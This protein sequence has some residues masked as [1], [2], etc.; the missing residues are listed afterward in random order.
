MPL[1][2]RRAR[3]LKQREIERRRAETTKAEAPGRDTR[4]ATREE[5]QVNPDPPEPLVALVPYTWTQ[6]H[7]EVEV[8]VE[9]G[10]AVR[11]QEIRVT[12]RPW[13]LSVEARTWHMHACV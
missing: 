2:L 10:A 7:A 12:V 11:K 1:Q 13:L 6:H 8:H 4:V 3:D 9:L 5:G